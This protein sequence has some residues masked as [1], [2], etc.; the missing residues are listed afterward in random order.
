M[1]KLIVKFGL[2]FKH[3]CENI[4]G[5]D[6]LLRTDLDKI[7]SI[8]EVFEII[9][10]FVLKMEGDKSITFSLVLPKLLIIQKS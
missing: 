9:G 2:H 3:S 5:I 4:L 7:S 10:D 8:K 1:V 6:Y